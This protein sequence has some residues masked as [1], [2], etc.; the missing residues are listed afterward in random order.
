MHTAR[1]GRN[2]DLVIDRSD[3]IARSDDKSLISYPSSSDM[4][5]HP[6]KVSLSIHSL[7]H[8]RGAK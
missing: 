1:E 4:V 5:C 8:V 7:C 2:V 3:N 6:I